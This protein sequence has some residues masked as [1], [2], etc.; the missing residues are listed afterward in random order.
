MIDN[1]ETCK[2]CGSKNLLWDSSI[3]DKPSCPMKSRIATVFLGCE[4]CSETL[5]IHNVDSIVDYLN[6]TRP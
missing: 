6:R 4:D 1:P 3:I 5:K 2:H